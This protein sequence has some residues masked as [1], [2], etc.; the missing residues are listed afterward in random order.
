MNALSANPS[1]HCKEG[2]SSCV[3]EKM[4][5]AFCEAMTF[6]MVCDQMIHKPEG[7]FA[8]IKEDHK[9][10][11]LVSDPILLVEDLTFVI[12]Q[13]MAYPLVSVLDPQSRSYSKQDPSKEKRPAV[14]PVQH[15]NGI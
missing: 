2:L 9:R 6:Q 5:V 1:L 14:K 11:N 8:S 7:A 3:R 4:P 13:T 15:G 10:S 12:Q